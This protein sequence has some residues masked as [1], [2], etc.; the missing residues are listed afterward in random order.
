MVSIKTRDVGRQLSLG[1][2]KIGLGFYPEKNGE[3]ER[4]EGRKEEPSYSSMGESRHRKP[5]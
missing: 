3:P 4:E 2:H 1:S 5:G